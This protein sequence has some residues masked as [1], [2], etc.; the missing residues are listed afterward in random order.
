MHDAKVDETLILAALTEMKTARVLPFRFVAAA[1]YAPQWE[2]PL[3]QAMFSCVGDQPKLKGKTVLLVDV[4]GSMDEPLSRKAEMT[5]ANAGYGLAVLVR[6][7]CETLEIYSFSDRTVRIPPRRGFA[8]RDAIHPSQP[9]G[10]TMLGAA[11]ER[12]PGT[13]DRLIVITDEQ[14]HGKV[15]APTS[16][17][18]I[19]NVASYKHGVGYGPWVHID[20]WSEAVIDFIR[21]LESYRWV[22]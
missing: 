7:L 20:G 3:E 13:Y 16:V 17:G 12:V 1:R 15:P 6:E 2:T 9:H 18:Y 21:E 8:L 4:S 5:R 22:N 19:I 10:A 11:V 14:A